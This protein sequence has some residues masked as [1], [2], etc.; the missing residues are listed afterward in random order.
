[1]KNRINIANILRDYPKG[2][3]LYSPLCGKVTLE[4]IDK[5]NHII[6]RTEKGLM[7]IFTEEGEYSISFPY[8]VC[9]LFPSEECRD[10]DKLTLYKDGDILATEDGRPFIFNGKTSEFGNP[11]SYG[12]IFT[13]N[14]FIKM[15]H[16][17][18]WTLQHF[19]KAT[20]REVSQLKDAMRKAVFIWD[21][22]NKKVV[23]DLPGGSLV[24]V[25]SGLIDD[26]SIDEWRI[27]R[28]RGFGEC[29]V[30]GFSSERCSDVSKWSTIIPLDKL[31]LYDDGTVNLSGVT[32]YGSN[33]NLK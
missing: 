28:Y 12:G 5:D 18:V 21:S 3:K 14:T 22:V 2:T 32:N 6:C 25:K 23:K 26:E 31:S 9:V 8:D 19:R 10:W 11:Y 30:N 24:L 7:A 16:S 4:S 29:Y 13:Y 27:R 17:D 20:D 33:Q 1:M 15:E